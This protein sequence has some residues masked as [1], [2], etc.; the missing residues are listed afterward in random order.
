MKKKTK[1]KKNSSAPLRCFQS[2]FPEE[3]SGRN[4]PGSSLTYSRAP[5]VDSV[6]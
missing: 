4:K 1:Q 5:A 3:V 2:D 6:T